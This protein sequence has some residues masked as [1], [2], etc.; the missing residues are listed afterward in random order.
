VLSKARDRER[1]RLEKKVRLEGDFFQPKCLP[2]NG[3]I[4]LIYNPAKSKVGEEVWVAYKR[5]HIK[6]TVPELDIDGNLIPEF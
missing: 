2:E 5:G 3:N 6:A 1:K 4:T